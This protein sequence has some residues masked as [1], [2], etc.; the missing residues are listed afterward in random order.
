MLPPSA[1]RSTCRLA[2]PK[3]PATVIAKQARRCWIFSQSGS[4]FTW[5]TAASY[6]APRSIIRKRSADEVRTRSSSDGVFFARVISW[7]C[8]ADA[9]RSTTN[10]HQT[11]RKKA[12]STLTASSRNFVVDFPGC[13]HKHE[14]TLR[15]F[16]RFRYDQRRCF[17]LSPVKDSRPLHSAFFR[18]RDLLFTFGEGD[19]DA[20]AAAFLHFLLL[21]LRHA[22]SRKVQ[23][24]ARVHD[25]VLRLVIGHRS[26]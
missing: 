17:H 2:A 26:L 13:P 3:P 7:L 9:K 8:F 12:V 22:F 4:R 15:L 14:V 5:T 24:F 25:A 11:A 18:I 6:N 19:A 23:P 16:I 10:L 1:P 20:H 21:H